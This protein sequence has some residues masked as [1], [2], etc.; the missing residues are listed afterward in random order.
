LSDSIA[1]S[2]A[3]QPAR[4]PF[5]RWFILALCIAGGAWGSL[6]GS[7]VLYSFLADGQTL[8]EMAIVD[9]GYLVGNLMLAVTL[10]LSVWAGWMVVRGRP[11]LGGW[12]LLLI[13][14]LVFM[15]NFG[16]LSYATYAAAQL[17]PLFIAAFLAGTTGLR[18]NPTLATVAVVSWLS[19]FSYGHAKDVIQHEFQQ[20]ILNGDHE[21]A[22]RF[23]KL[24]AEARPNS[25]PNAPMLDAVLNADAEMVRLLLDHGAVPYRTSSFGQSPMALAIEL[26]HSEVVLVMVES[27]G[28]VADADAKDA[29]GGS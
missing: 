21:N 27:R 28:L 16:D 4:R 8:R 3:N 10:P 14:G 9:P 18:R 29:G 2:P 20:S 19:F 17:L 23:L 13:P 22:R 6:F 5:S 11:R 7:F 1:D 25:D 15:A 12:V 26:G 24:G